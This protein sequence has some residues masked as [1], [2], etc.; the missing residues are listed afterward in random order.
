MSLKNAEFLDIFV[1]INSAEL[2]MEKV[3]QTSGLVLRSRISLKTHFHTSQSI[4][5]Y[6]FYFSDCL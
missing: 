6:S 1:L 4:C 3:L 5:S 2:S